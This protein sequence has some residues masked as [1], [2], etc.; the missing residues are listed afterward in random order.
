M[1]LAATESRLSL[2]LSPGFQ[3]GHPESQQGRQLLREPIGGRH[4]GIRVC[5]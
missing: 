5:A 2:G 1:Q 4:S 3:L